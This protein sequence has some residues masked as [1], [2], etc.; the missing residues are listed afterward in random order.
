VCQTEDLPSCTWQSEC[1]SEMYTV[2]WSMCLLTTKHPPD[3]MVTSI[4]IYVIQVY[5]LVYTVI[6]LVDTLQYKPEGRGFD[7]RLC[8][9]FCLSWPWN[10][11]TQLK[12][13]SLNIL[14]PPGP[15]QGLLY[16]IYIYIYIYIYVCVCV[17]GYKLQTVIGKVSQIL[18][19]TTK[20][21]QKRR[22]LHKQRQQQEQQISMLKNLP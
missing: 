2:F 9:N 17:V 6:Q 22:R 7:S 10:R 8:P 11:I 20:I 13:G 1:Y 3:V 5:V 4:Y 14:E 12:S 16:L 21:T 18:H 15:V 19:S